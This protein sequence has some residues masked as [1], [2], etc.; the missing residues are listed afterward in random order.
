MKID[1]QV[2]NGIWKDRYSKNGENIDENLHRVANYIGSTTQEKSDFFNVMDKGLFFPAGR[3]M[4]NSGIGTNLTLNNCFVANFVEDNI[5]DIFDKVKL[6]ALTHKRGGGIGYDF[7]KLRPRGSLTSNDAIASGV[8]SF[9]DVFNTQTATILQGGRRGAN[10]GIL[11]IYHPDIFDYL[12]AKSFDEGRLTHF[13]LSIMIDDNFMNAKNKNEKIILHYPIYDNKGLMINDSSQWIYTKEFDANQLWDI[14]MTKAYNTGEY[15]VFFY[16]NLNRDNNTYY[17]ETI[18]CT[19]PCFTGDMKLLTSEGYKNFKEISG[20]NVEL[21]NHQGETSHGTVWSNGIKDIIKLRL[22]NGKEIK[23]TPDHRFMVNNG[24]ECQAKDLLNKRV[25][26]F[27]GQLNNDLDNLYIKLGFIQGDGCTG[28]INSESHKGM[29]IN[30]GYHDNDIRTLFA[31]E[32]I[33]VTHSKSKSHAYYINGFNELLLELMFDGAPLPER[34]F[35]MTYTSW[36]KKKKSSFLNGCYS[37]NGSIITKYRISYKATSKV[38]ILQLQK[39]LKNDFNIDSYFTTN[40]PKVVAFANGDYECKESYDLNIGKLNDIIKFYNTIGFTQKYKVENLETL[41]SVKSPK[42]LSIKDCEKEEVFD[43][44]EPLTHWGSVEGV[45]VHNCGEYLSGLLYGKN[46]STNEEIKTEEYMGACNLGSLFLHNYVINPFTKQVRIDYSELKNAINIGV[47][48]LDNIIDINKFPHQ[49][50][51]NYQKNMRTIGLGD[52]GIA[53]VLT[54]FNI[55]YGSKKAIEFVDKLENFITKEAYKSSIDLAR[56]KG[57]FP[58]LDRE[59]FVQSGFILK[60]VKQDV[61]WQQIVKDILIYGIRNARIRTEAPVGTLSLTFGNNCSS[62]LEPI[63]SLDYDRKVKIGGQDESD[64]QIV[65]MEDYA[66]G[67]WK[68]TDKNNIVKE[69]IFVTAMNLPVQSHLDMLKAI[70]FHVDMSCS[71]TINIPTDYPY[72]ETKKVYDYCWENGIK[73][74]TIFRPNPIRQGIMVTNDQSK[75]EV[76]T[77]KLERGQWK[78][79]ASDTFYYERKLTIGCG[80][81]MLFIGWSDSEKEVQDFFV[82]RS[83]RGGCEKNIQTS[84]I[85]MS[86]MLRLGGKLE[87]IERAFEG[88]GGCNSFVGQRAKGVKLSKGSS[89]GT[90]ILNEI[91]SFHSEM[92]TKEIKEIII[93]KK[94]VMPQDIDI[95]TEELNYLKENGEIAFAKHYNKCPVCG[96]H[97]ENTGGC[98]ICQKGCGWSKCE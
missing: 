47:R 90:V 92:N 52:T 81:L 77:N 57:S 35:P 30:M 10:M 55:K 5:E 3:T 29:E 26:A 65:K 83:G 32:L 40:K 6:G 28:R 74:S 76:I 4:S 41:I 12:D 1:N 36:D 72:I 78:P 61:E 25:M 31:K 24:E 2:L 53:D 46:P 60:H 66:Y 94:Q 75:V 64:I 43:F 69:D 14:I 38:F 49:A 62:G 91:K 96:E 80:K 19:N 50:Y 73:G 23:C 86:G 59:K 45:I 39:A 98:M 11:S 17:M 51:E 67:L 97:L 9:M 87:N 58:F 15:G 48:L 34:V 22:S 42:V 79:K 88:V 21:V 54:M 95:K 18:V 85:A 44:N 71:K 16:D 27:K 7:S 8:C 56:E 68:R 37:A 89:C 20:M 33:G 84:V 70:A 13:N 93:P 82:I 63:F